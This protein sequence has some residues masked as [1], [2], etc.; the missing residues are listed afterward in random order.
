KILHWLKRPGDQVRP[1]EPLAE[2][3]TDKADMVLEAFEAGVLQELRLAEGQSAPVGAVIALLGAPGEAQA[4]SP[5]A[6]SQAPPAQEPEV[7][8]VVE[9]RQP[10]TPS[11]Q[12]KDKP[13]AIGSS[14]RL[15]LAHSNAGEARGTRT[16][17]TETPEVE[18]TDPESF[19]SATDEQRSD[20]PIMVEAPA[21]AAEATPMPVAREPRAIWADNNPGRIRVTPL[22]RRA[23]EEAGIDLSS[24]RGSGVEGRITKRDVDSVVRAR[25]ATARAKGAGETAAAADSAIPAGAGGAGAEQAVVMR[26]AARNVAPGIPTFERVPG[27][28]QANSRMRRAIAQRLTASKQEIPHYYVTVE[29]DMEEA[30]RLKK[31]LESTKLFD[32][33]ITYNDIV[34]KACALALTRHPH[35]NSSFSEGSIKIHPSVNIGVAVAVEEGLIVPIIK[36]CQRLSLPEIAR[37]AHGLAAKAQQGGFTAEDLSGGTFT[38]SNMG[39][40]GIEH[41]VAVINPPQAAILAVAAI[42]ERPVLRN[43]Q[44]VVGTTMMMTLSCDHRIIDGVVAGRFLLEVKRFLENPPSLLM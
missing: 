33:S 6:A 27:T 12:A 35:I 37:L 10:I 31:S 9:E 16:A 2:V 38:I 42:K 43:G 5:T 3:E 19:L 39:M 21:P 44:V 8:E 4:P 28:Y 34:I 40:L 20:A 14:P 18:A 23:A 22:A 24:I 13:R 26:E 1:G 30:V 17:S 11:A 7:V 29:V 15:T 41:F 25:A 36:D 32:Q